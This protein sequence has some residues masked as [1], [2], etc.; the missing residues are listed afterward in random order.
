MVVI[1][2]VLCWLVYS[3]YYLCLP[4]S[5]FPVQAGEKG[6]LS[7]LIGAGVGAGIGHATDR[8]GGSGK[9]AVIGAIGGYVIGDQM[10]KA[11]TRNTQTREET[12]QRADQ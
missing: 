1:R 6:I 2:D 9:G 12:Y 3:F 10:D 4:Y 7:A 8:T 5:L 11:E